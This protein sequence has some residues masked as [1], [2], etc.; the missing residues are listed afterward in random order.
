M[1]G[2]EKLAA[3]KDWRIVKK[4]EAP[5]WFASNKENRRQNSASDA[6]GGGEVPDAWKD[7]LVTQGKWRGPFTAKDWKSN[8]ASSAASNAGS[9]AGDLKLRTGDWVVHDVL[10]DTDLPAALLSKEGFSNW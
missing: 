5:K 8:S 4:E 7:A 3:S 9:N 1:G 10:D 2:F 6:A